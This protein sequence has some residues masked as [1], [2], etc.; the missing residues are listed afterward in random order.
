MNQNS[1][2]RAVCAALATV[3]VF[4]A[5][6]WPQFRGPAGVG[7]S[8]EPGVPT[9]WS[10]EE[11]VVWK[12]RL[13]GFGASSP[14]TLGERIFVTCY[15]GYGLDRDEP[16]PQEQLLHHVVC[17]DRPT[18]KTL[19]DRRSRARLPEREYG[20]LVALHG[21]ASGTPVTDGEAVYAFFGQSGVWAYGL[22]GELLWR[23]DVGKGT[24]DWGS[25]SSP[26][27]AGQLL[28]V[29]A[30]VESQAVVAL[31]KQSGDEVWRAGD[32]KESWSTPALVDLPD[33][34]QELVVSMH[35]KVRGYHPSTGEQLWE[36]AGVDDYVVPAVVAHQG[37]VYVAGGR[38]PQLVAIRAGGRGNVTDSHL[39]WE[40]RSSSKVPTPV[41]FDGHLYW[42]NQRGIAACVKADSG[43][44][45]YEERLRIGGS[46]D[47][48]YA[49]LVVADGKLYGVTRQDGTVVLPAEPRFEELARNQLG[50]DSIF[51]ATPA[52]GAGQL[53]LR[54]DR[55][56]YCIGE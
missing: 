30:S 39:L 25:G 29:N 55:F 38:R 13:P 41:Y 40:I 47:K 15:S 32:V 45:V 6:D 27:L 12:T 10:A 9:T 8:R 4:S 23:V 7:V 37:V 17:V 54:S 28:V 2:C 26:I 44:L 18:G 50:D 20:G 36:C 5:A 52:P 48:I 11:N 24:H 1:I 14:I 31:N 51:N 16:G 34:R 56:L 35:S 49:S 53:L 19:W 46:G 33:G 42:I 43:E 21:Y 22:D 3:G